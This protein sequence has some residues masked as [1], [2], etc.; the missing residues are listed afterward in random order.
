M[1]LPGNDPGTLSFN[2]RPR[3]GATIPSRAVPDA[4]A[5]SIRAPVRGRRVGPDTAAIADQSVFNPR[6]REGATVIAR[7]CA[8]PSVV[9]QS[10]P[11]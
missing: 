7:Q 4:K 10:A 5:V 11:P 3:E 9:F 8:H 1:P 6:P 2:P